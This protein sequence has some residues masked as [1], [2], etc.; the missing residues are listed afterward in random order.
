VAEDQVGL[1]ERLGLRSRWRREFQQKRS[2]LTQATSK[3]GKGDESGLSCSFLARSTKKTPDRL[4]GHTVIGGH[5]AQGFVVLTDT[6][7]HVRPCFKWKGMV[8]LTWTW[9]LLGGDDRGKTAKH[10]L[11]CKE[12][13]IEL[14]VRGHKVDQHW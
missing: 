14:A 1:S 12:S 9:M 7:H 11:Q 6:A 13:V 10:V 2:Q 8:R 5:L 3:T 4:V